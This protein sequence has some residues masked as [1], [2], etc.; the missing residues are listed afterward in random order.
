VLCPKDVDCSKCFHKSFASHPKS[1]CWD[2]LEGKN[3][4]ESGRKISP[5]EVFIGGSY[6]ADFICDEC[7]H[8]FKMTCNNVS[9]RFWCGFC[10]GH[11]RCDSSTCDMC[12]GRKL[13]SHPFS[14][15]WNAELNP[16][17]IS[18]LDIALGN[19]VDKFWFN[20]PAEKHPPYQKRATDINRGGG[21]PSCLRKTEAKIGEFL[22]S[23]PGI[24]GYQKEWVAEWLRNPITK[25][26]ARFDFML[27]PINTVIENDGLQHFIDGRWKSKVFIK[28]DSGESKE[29]R[30]RDLEKMAKSIEH[31]ISGIR[32]FQPDV[33][34]DKYD[35]K[36]WII[37]ALDFIKSSLLP[38]W[39]FPKNTIYESHIQ[40]CIERKL[41]YI[42]L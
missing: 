21:C 32:L 30:K 14:E 12:N 38:V 6:E 8:P 13:S 41:N 37:T 9:T 18:P 36:G 19:C 24:S 31:G 7:D 42:I 39:V 1:G 29:Q 25:Y 27:L 34:V 33:L 16:K 2:I 3:I 17:D 22:P 15:Y 4:D 23:I 35:W 20:C 5:R 28:T 10:T 40:L 26:C 11:R